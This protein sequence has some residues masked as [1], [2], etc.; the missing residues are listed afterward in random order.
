MLCRPLALLA[1]A[2]S[3]LEALEDYSA[4][5][6]QH[7]LAAVVADSAGLTK[8]RHTQAAAWARLRRAADAAGEAAA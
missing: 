2:A 1:E 3:C 7:H 5:A 8:Q 6:E 4:A